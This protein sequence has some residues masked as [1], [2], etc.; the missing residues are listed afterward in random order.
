MSDT[1][2]EKLEANLE[3]LRASFVADL[4]EVRQGKVATEKLI[5]F[6][7]GRGHFAL[8]TSE[9]ARIV[10][11]EATLV[12]VPAAP[13]HCRGAYAFHQEIFSVI[14]L[15]SL[16]SCG[17]VEEEWLILL[18]PLE[19]RISLSV[20]KLEGLVANEGSGSFRAGDEVVTILDVGTL[21]SR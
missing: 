8:K 12:E 5:H 18:K 15:S 3:E 7:S 1:L 17:D 9:V 4:H 21:L 11:L 10:K 19:A 14:S 13:P 16:L 6:S 20:E 2:L